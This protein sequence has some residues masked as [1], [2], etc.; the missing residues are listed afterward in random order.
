MCVCVCVCVC[1]CTV[2]VRV[3]CA[4]VFVGGWVGGW[5]ERDGWGLDM[6][7]QGHVASID[8]RFHF[9]A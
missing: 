2:C 1:V 6:D 9:F 4:C 3:R 8:L 5:V 7:E